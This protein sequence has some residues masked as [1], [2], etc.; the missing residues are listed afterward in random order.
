MGVVMWAC[1]C[2][3]VNEEVCR[4]HTWYTPSIA[5]YL[6]PPADSEGGVNNRRVGRG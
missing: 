3:G 6:L 1:T 5:P 4:S 2:S